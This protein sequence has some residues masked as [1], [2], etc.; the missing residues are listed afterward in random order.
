VERDLRAS[1]GRHLIARRHL[2]RHLIAR[3]D[4]VYVQSVR[5]S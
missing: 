5:F 3:T 4:F 2:G 1:L